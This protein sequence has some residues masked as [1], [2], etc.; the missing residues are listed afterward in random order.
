M[1]WIIRPSFKKI[2]AGQPGYINKTEEKNTDQ[3]MHFENIPVNSLK[4]ICWVPRWIK[5][6][7]NIGT[8][9][10]KPQSTSPSNIK[11]IQ[12]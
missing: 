4:I 3:V 1:N 8:N 11:M 10:I 7:N 6:Y 2:L 5:Q 12:K 9:K